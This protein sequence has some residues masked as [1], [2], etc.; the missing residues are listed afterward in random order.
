MND[1]IDNNSFTNHFSIQTPKKSNQTIKESPIAKSFRSLFKNHFLQ[2]SYKKS[3]YFPSNKTTLQ[4][5]FNKSV[6]NKP[7]SLSFF[8]NQQ[9]S[10]SRMD[11]FSNQYK[12]LLL[13]KLTDEN[14]EAFNK[15]ILKE[16]MIFKDFTKTFLVNQT[17]FGENNE[18]IAKTHSNGNGND[19]YYFLYKLDEFFQEKC[20]EVI[21]LQNL[22]EKFIKETF[23]FIFDQ[24]QFL[25]FR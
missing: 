5:T 6:E 4:S 1:K 23:L 18:N 15:K 24:M 16:F 21:G 19:I 14:F 12:K 10:S 22:T 13:G 8:K 11:S 20:L 7:I 2:K 3:N 17:L 25:N 9:L